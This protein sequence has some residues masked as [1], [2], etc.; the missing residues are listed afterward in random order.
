MAMWPAETCHF[1]EKEKTVILQ[2]HNLQILLYKTDEKV[3]NHRVSI[4]VSE[5]NESLE[6]DKIIKFT[7]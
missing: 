2:I 3:D 6:G 1:T 4:Y 7:T 5:I